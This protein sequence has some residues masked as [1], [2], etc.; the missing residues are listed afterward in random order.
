M[1]QFIMP[2]S[3][4]DIKKIQDGIKE[5][6]SALLR[7]ESERDLIKDISAKLKDEVEL[8]PSVF[9]KMAKVYFKNEYAK[10]TEAN[11]TFIDIYET[12]MNGI[13]PDLAVV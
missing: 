1:T 9:N 12:V 4:A 5:A 7:I 11:E 2:S 3:P 8:P 10:V 13:D 6:S